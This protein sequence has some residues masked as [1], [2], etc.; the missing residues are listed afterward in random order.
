LPLTA[1]DLHAGA[2]YA[3]ANDV[4]SNVY[5]L[6]PSQASTTGVRCNVIGASGASVALT[7]TVPFTWVTGDMLVLAGTYEIA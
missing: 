1:K 4:G 5:L 2:F 3:E 7:S 6:Y